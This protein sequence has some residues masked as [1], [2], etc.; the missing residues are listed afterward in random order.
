MN[1]NFHIRRSTAI[2]TLIIAALVGGLVA[3]MSMNHTAALPVI[4]NARAATYEPGP[5]V[6]FAP[7]VKRAMP[8]VVNISS[9][10]VIKNQQQN[11]YGNMFDDPFFRRFFGGRMPEAPRERRAESLGS[12][13]IV[14]PDGY[15]LTNNHVVEGATQVKVSFSDRREFPAKVIGTD[16]PTDVAV[17]KID[18]RDLPVLPI[19]D[20]AHAQVGDVVLAIGDPFGVGQTVTMGIVSATGRSLGGA[21]ERFEDFIQT[22]AAINPGNSGGALINTKG[23]LVGINTAILA[24]NTGGNQGI[25]FAIPAN[26]ARNIMDQILKSGKVTRGFI[27]ILPQE[28]TPDM[29][30][31]FGSP[32]L[33]GVAVAEVSDNTPASRA[34]MKVGDVITAINHNPVTDVN[35]FRLQVAG[36]APGTKIDLSVNRNGREMDVP[37]TLAQ[38]DAKNLSGPQDDNNDDQ[39]A[40][41]N[42]GEKGALKGVSVQ[43]L[44]ADMREQLQLPANSQGVIVTDVDPSSRA[45]DAGLQQNDVIVQVNHK[46]VASVSQFNTAVRETRGSTLLLVKRGGG[47]LFIAVQE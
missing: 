9:S 10:K 34:G 4:G 5:L 17:L 11:G 41:P 19:A 15:I 12:G 46:P 36:M 42:Q 13:V 33:K 47:S 1:R 39:G 20:S 45:A 25:G 6:S 22:D 24:G 40:A 37:V 23:E 31:A 7:T 44:N 18:Q 43:G 8:A 21:I 28:L 3:S 16:A 35:Q 32:N 30:K 14:S 38:M 29:A 26:L 2:L 27:G